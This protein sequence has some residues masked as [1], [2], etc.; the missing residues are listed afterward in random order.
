M[1]DRTALALAACEGMSNE[2]LA[3]RGANGFPKMI[4]RKRK[5]ATLARTLAVALQAALKKNKAL[6]TELAIAKATIAQLEALDKPITDTTQAAELLAG[7]L[8][9][10]G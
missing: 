5:Y 7:A 8:K 6:E 3:N 2:D 1:A 4:L 10:Q 9:K